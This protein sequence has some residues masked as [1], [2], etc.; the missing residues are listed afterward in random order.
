MVT[1]F[2]RAKNLVYSTLFKTGMLRVFQQVG[3]GS[4]RLY[5]LCYHRVDEADHRPRLTPVTLS[6]TPDQFREQMRLIASRYTPV[7]AEE[8]LAALDGGPSL[9]PDAVLVTVDDG[10]RD[11]KETIFPIASSYGIRPVLFVPTAFPGRGGFWWDRLYCAVYHA[12]GERLSTP[13]GTYPLRNEAEK[14]KA[15]TSLRA[16]IL[17]M[18][19][20]E[21]MQIVDELPVQPDS[22][23]ALPDVLDWEELRE[24]SR[25]GATIAAHTHTHPALTRLPLEQARDEIRKSQEVVRSEIGEALPIFAFP[26]GN[27]QFFSQPLTD[28]LKG[29]GFKFAVTTVEGSAALT[30]TNALCFPRLGVNPALTHQ[31]L[32]FHLTPA[33]S[34]IQSRMA[35]VGM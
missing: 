23:E 3:R 30:S 16:S 12:P 9:P 6:A 11:F 22:N 32:Y 19:F 27:P 34:W 14:Q 21:G 20:P 33:Y 25:A 35:F 7:S 1:I 31:A 10:Y 15:F 13:L 18:S 28:F 5:V 29:D 4:S 17:S 26:Y 8:I 24:L 2:R